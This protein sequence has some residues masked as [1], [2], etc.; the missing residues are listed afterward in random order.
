[1]GSNDGMGEGN[2]SVDEWIVKGRQKAMQMNFE[3]A[4][5]CFNE[6]LKIDPRHAKALNNKGSMYFQL[7]NMDDAMKNFEM[8][9]E[10]DPNL[11]EAEYG[12]AIVYNA[13]NRPSEAIASFEKFIANAPP[14]SQQQVQYAQQ[15]LMSL[16]GQQ[17][18]TGFPGNA[19]QLSPEQGQMI[20]QFMGNQQGQQPSMGSFQFPSQSSGSG[21]RIGNL[22][23]AQDYLVSW[24]VFGAIAGVLGSVI[25]IIFAN[26]DNLLAQVN[27]EITG[28]NNAATA[29]ALIGLFGNLV[30]MTVILLAY[31]KVSTKL[32]GVI[33]IIWA[34]IQLYIISWYGIPAAL[35]FGYAGL[36]GLGI[37]KKK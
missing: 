2:K 28:I 18:S 7:Q 27:V 12:K 26:Y 30:F 25:C 14:N 36:Y 24:S 6:A 11:V 9:L 8:A 33:V 1:M 34:A 17:P 21:P 3:G 19:S 22:S 29:M 31:K 10:A 32:L 37:L 15:C 13:Q 20:G 4:L 23:G 16:K 5:E 35:I